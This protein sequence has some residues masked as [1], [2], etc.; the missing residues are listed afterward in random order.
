M[1]NHAHTGGRHL[2][3]GT[4]PILEGAFVG[5]KL[6][7]ERRRGR[8]GRKGRQDASAQRPTESLVRLKGFV[9]PFR[10][11]KG[12]THHNLG[13]IHTVHPPPPSIVVIVIV[14][15]GLIC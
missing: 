13:A 15:V 8:V 7:L 11:G 4:G 14:V 6:G 1:G 2:D 10:V 5:L 3:G 12:T 9:Q